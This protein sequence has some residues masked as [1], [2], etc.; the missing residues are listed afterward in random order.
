MRIF[1]SSAQKVRIKRKNTT[2]STDLGLILPRR[3]SK[4]FRSGDERCWLWLKTLYFQPLNLL[5]M[6]VLTVNSF[7]LNHSRFSEG[8]R[9]RLNV[10]DLAVSDNR[11]F[12]CYTIDITVDRAVE[13]HLCAGSVQTSTTIELVVHL[14]IIGHVG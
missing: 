14:L 3:R 10:G 4:R 11:P 8:T 7:F 12:S 5:F 13:Y 6:V 2:I 9:F 1:E